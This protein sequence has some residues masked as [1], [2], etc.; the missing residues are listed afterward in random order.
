MMCMVGILTMVSGGIS[1]KSHPGK[2]ETKIHV[3]IATSLGGP[4][5]EIKK[6]YQKNHP[7]VNITY[8][9]DSSGTLLTQIQE[10]HECDIFFCAATKQMDVLEREGYVTKGTRKDLLKNQLVLI[11]AKD[12]GTKVTAFSNLNRAK[13]MALAGGS[14]PAGKYTRTILVKL[15]LL[16][17][18]EDPSV[19]TSEEISQILHGVEINECSNVS[20]VTEAVKE[21]A[22]EI[23]TVYYS[24]AY[25]V[26]DQ[27][28]IIDSADASLTG[29]ILYPVA[30]LENKEADES[31]RKEVTDFLSYLLS[32]DA[33]TIFEQYMFHYVG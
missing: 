4:M 6:E 26:K 16:P 27:V 17:H 10:G 15:G 1:Q 2:E 8:N 25:L 18:V 22:N 5:E 33:K 3:F 11:T 28:S 7:E 12:S 30:Q 29:E 32:E 13:S 23:G 20:K 24:D 31:Q 9:A 14:V 21:G 19:Y